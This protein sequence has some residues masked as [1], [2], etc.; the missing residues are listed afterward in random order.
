M[1]TP[2]SQAPTG[3]AL[4]QAFAGNPVSSAHLGRLAEEFSF[5]VGH[6]VNTIASC[7]VRQRP[8]GRTQLGSINPKTY[9]CAWYRSAGVQIV[10]VEIDLYPGTTQQ[11]STVSVTL[12]TGAAW[13]YQGGIDGSTAH[14]HPLTG[15]SEV[16]SLVGYVDVSGCATNTLLYWAIVLTQSSGTGGGLSRVTLTEVP[17]SI[18]IP[19]TDDVIDQS[20]TVAGNKLWDGDNTT[21]YGLTRINLALDQARKYSRK[22]FCLIGIEGTDTAAVA[23]N[24]LWYVDGNGGASFQTLHLQQEY[25]PVA[26]TSQ[27]WRMQVR[28][29]YSGTAETWKL[30]VRYRTAT[31]TGGTFRLLPAGVGG[32]AASAQDLTLTATSGSWAWVSTDV[33]IPVDGTDGIVELEFQCKNNQTAGNLIQFAA[34]DLIDTPS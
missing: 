15:T 3:F 12:P 19:P 30:A 7:S 4:E 20:W 17:T 16:G 9:P 34:I 25:Q 14:V 21:G 5:L 11:T 24:G 31:A 8:S 6:N 33:T 29:L 27:Y 23:L 18:L 2:V 32:A 26:L 1:S 13:K 28:N 22:H 10:R